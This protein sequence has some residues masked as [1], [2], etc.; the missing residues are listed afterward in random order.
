MDGG[1][2]GVFDLAA[3]ADS[4][5]G[6]RGAQYLVVGGAEQAVGLGNLKPVLRQGAGLVEADGA[7]PGERPMAR[8][9]RTST[10]DP[11]RF[12]ADDDCASVT[13][14][15]RPSGTGDTDTDHS[16]A[17]S[18]TGVPRNNDNNP[19]SAPPAR[20]KGNAPGD[21]AELRGQPHIVESVGGQRQRLAD[22]CGFARCG[23]HADGFACDDGTSGE[24]HSGAFGERC[25]CV[26][27]P[28]LLTG[29]DS[30]VSADSSTS[31][32][33]ASMMR[34][35]AVPPRRTGP[36]RCRRGAGRRRVPRRSCPP[37]IA[38]HFGAKGS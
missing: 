33:S 23:H 12:R 28:S 19:T 25:R 21:R 18:R 24:Q 14:S 9:L 13:T 2:G 35:S 7:E 1:V 11:V 3:L 36:P 22:L 26:S 38:D 6:T 29:S 5:R 16:D 37:R 8:G 17:A 27:A 31:T 15:G 30:P 32:V 4:H 10:D 34:I 20:L